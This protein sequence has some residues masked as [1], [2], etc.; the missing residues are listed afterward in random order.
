MFWWLASI[1]ILFAIAFRF[2]NAVER[3]LIQRAIGVISQDCAVVEKSTLAIPVKHNGNDY[4]LHVP[5]NRGR[6][7][8]RYDIVAIDES[9]ERTLN[10]PRGVPFMVTPDDI[11]VQKIVVKRA[12]GTVDEYSGNGVVQL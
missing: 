2:R 8:R 12:N 11:G 1:G 9:G 3:Y 7:L 4:M 5:F 10:H 6:A